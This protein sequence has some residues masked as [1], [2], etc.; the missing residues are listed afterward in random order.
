M[1]FIQGGFSYRTKKELALNIEVGESGYVDHRIRDANDYARHMEYIRQNPVEAEIVV[2]A[3]D[4]V[5]SS[6][7]AGFEV[8]PCP[9][10]GPG[11]G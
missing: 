4:Y 8:D 7:S 6:A 3:E 2:R 9:L 10:D 5:S 1:Q 11:K